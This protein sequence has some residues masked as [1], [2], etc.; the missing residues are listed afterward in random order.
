MYADVYSRCLIEW[1]GFRPTYEGIDGEHDLFMSVIGRTGKRTKGFS[2]ALIPESGGM[3]SVPII[4]IR[5]TS[6]A[7]R[8][9]NREEDR[10]SPNYFTFF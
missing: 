1:R 2:F 9:A 10:A 4:S 6:S 5:R 8:R 3:A 7:L